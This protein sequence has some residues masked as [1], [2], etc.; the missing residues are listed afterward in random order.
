MSHIYEFLPNSRPATNEN[1][2]RSILPTGRNA[3]MLKNQWAEIPCGNRP[4]TQGNK[5]QTLPDIG[6]KI[7]NKSFYSKQEYLKVWVKL[8]K[9]S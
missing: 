4:W 1:T 7:I 5:I 2:K 8:P 9:W 3:R 6:T